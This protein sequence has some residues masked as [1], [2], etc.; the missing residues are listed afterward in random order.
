M[1]KLILLFIFINGLYAV[2]CPIGY[3]TLNNKCIKYFSTPL[4]YWDAYNICKQNKGNLLTISNSIDN[5]AIAAS[6]KNRTDTLWLGLQC[7]SDRNPSSCHWNDK[8][9]TS[10]A[11]YNNFKNGY[12]LI[13][14]GKCVNMFTSGSF[15]GKWLSE[16]CNST[17]LNFICESNIKDIDCQFV[18]GG[19]CYIPSINPMNQNDAQKACQ[20]LDANLVSIHSPQ[21][22]YFITSMIYN[23]SIDYIRIGAV[24]NDNSKISWL[25]NTTFD[26][27]NVGYQNLDYGK[28]F[29]LSLRRQTVESGEWISCYE[30]SAFPFVCKRPLNN[31]TIVIDDC[32][33]PH[34]YNGTGGF[35]SPNYPHSYVGTPKQQC[36]YFI[37]S[38]HI[39]SKAA[40]RFPIITLDDKASISLFNN[41]NDQVPFQVLTSTN[42]SNSWFK[43]A[44]NSMKVIFNPCLENCD[45]VYSHLFIASFG[46]F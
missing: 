40:I 20:E 30:N 18:M 7:E 31:Q 13:G 2:I 11:N 44:T 14:V 23:I 27:N 46:Y 3:Q 37:H 17:S 25:D 9:N 39:F 26:Y 36:Q 1:L 22:N 45:T 5:S 6:F 33:L 15:A 19:D 42:S 24:M 10:A 12:P 34:F 21:E 16:D 28:S 32:T 43:S 8:Y 29:C 4:K 35:V 38:G 41:F